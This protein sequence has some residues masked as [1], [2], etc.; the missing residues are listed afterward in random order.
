V[1]YRLWRNQWSES[2]AGDV[3][4]W[5][6]WWQH[7]RAELLRVCDMI[8]RTRPVPDRLLDR[9]GVTTKTERTKRARGK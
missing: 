8:V 5:R 6:Y 2:R 3:K 9:L 4:A 1:P 7:D